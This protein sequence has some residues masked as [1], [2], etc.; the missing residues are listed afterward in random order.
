MCMGIR[1]GNVGCV[2]LLMRLMRKIV[3]DANQRKVKR[4]QKESDAGG[5]GES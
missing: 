5:L 1:N 3:K 2:D 4:N